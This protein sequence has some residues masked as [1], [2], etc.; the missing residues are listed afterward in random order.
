MEV[1]LFFAVFGSVL[2]LVLFSLYQRARQVHALV[3]EGV[4]IAGVVT[5]KHRF[6]QK[7]RARFS[8]HY[9]YTPN[10]RTRHGRAFV[11]REQFESHSEGQMLRVRYLAR[12]PS[13]SAPEFVL[14]Q[15]RRAQR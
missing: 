1:L 14:D 7:N 15:A 8:L 5:R 2:A 9:E 4:P 6:T 11:S 10:G 13:V 3:H 12:K